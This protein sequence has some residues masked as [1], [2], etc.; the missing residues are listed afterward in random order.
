ML[1]FK[2]INKAARMTQTNDAAHVTHLDVTGL[3]CPIPVLRARRILDD[4]NVGDHLVVKASDP[5]SVQDMPAFCRM[6]GHTLHMASVEDGNYIYEIEKSVS[7]TE[8]TGNV[9][10]IKTVARS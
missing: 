5:A 2:E 9:I 6:T 7:K 3:L 1:P 8:D 10:P 4:L